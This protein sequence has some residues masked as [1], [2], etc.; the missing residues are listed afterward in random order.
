MISL[1]PEHASHSNEITPEMETKK[2][3][4]LNETLVIADSTVMEEEVAGEGAREEVV[5]ITSSGNPTGAGQVLYHFENTFCPSQ[6]DR[7]GEE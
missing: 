2:N 4:A 1:A 3:A 7:G 5:S 6:Q